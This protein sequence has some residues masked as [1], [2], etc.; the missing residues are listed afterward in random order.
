MQGDWYR[1]PYHLMRVCPWEFVVIDYQVKVVLF[2]CRF[3]RTIRGLR[4]IECRAIVG[5]CL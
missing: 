2:S 4:S 5:S 3:D 1:D